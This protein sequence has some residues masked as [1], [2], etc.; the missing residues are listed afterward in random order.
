MD[1]YPSGQS[2]LSAFLLNFDRRNI[3]GAK[4]V[5]FCNDYAVQFGGS[6]TWSHSQVPAFGHGSGVIPHLDGS[7][8]K[9]YE[10]CGFT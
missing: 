1:E 8:I 4:L 5:S 6:K 9:N 7:T 10:E 3:C 2:P